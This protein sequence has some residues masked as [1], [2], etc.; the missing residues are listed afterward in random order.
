MLQFNS[1][2]LIIDCT[3]KTNK[4]RMSLLVISKQTII[5]ITFYIAFAFM[6]DKNTKNYL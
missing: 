1:E 4:Y 5:S 6:L 2:V 3:Y